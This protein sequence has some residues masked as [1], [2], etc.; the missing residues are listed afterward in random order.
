MENKLK[1]LSINPYI[2]WKEIEKYKLFG[3]GSYLVFMSMG[4]F[5]FQFSRNL[6]IV[7]SLLGTVS[8]FVTIILAER[9]VENA[10]KTFK[11]LFERK[12]ESGF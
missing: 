6:A 10:R 5:S 8:I 9:K 11:T 1:V 7:L 2:K 12:N 3:L 4:M